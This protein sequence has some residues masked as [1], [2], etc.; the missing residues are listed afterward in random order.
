[1]FRSLKDLYGKDIAEEEKLKLREKIFSQSRNEWSRRIAKQ[2]AH[3]FRGFGQQEINNAVIAHY[4][5][6]FKDL[7]LFESLY[8]AQGKDLARVVESI[9]QSIP[10]GGDPFDTVR[11]L[12]GK[13]SRPARP[14]S[15]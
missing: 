11:E 5:L 8:Q 12:V 9:V 7:Q 15:R 3:R 10:D 6:Y 13:K 14:P 2:P 1:M 4:L